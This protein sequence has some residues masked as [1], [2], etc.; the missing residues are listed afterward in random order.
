MRKPGNWKAFYV[1]R[2]DWKTKCYLLPLIRQ[3]SS[4][5]GCELHLLGGVDNPG[6]LE[7]LRLAKGAESHIFFYLNTSDE[8]KD[9][10][11]CFSHLFLPFVSPI[12]SL[13]FRELS[14]DIWIGGGGSNGF[15]RG[16]GDYLL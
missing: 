8:D 6:C 14:G 13:T 12:F 5:P 10:L 15:W 7:M 9:A 11:I 16:F 3:F 2:L 4:F 1:G